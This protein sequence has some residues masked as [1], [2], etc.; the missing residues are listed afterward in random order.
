MPLDVSLFV[1]FCTVLLLRNE[2][3]GWLT[4]PLDVSLFVE[5]KFWMLCG[6]GFFQMY[7]KSMTGLTVFERMFVKG[8]CCIRME[9]LGYFILFGGCHIFYFF[10][11]Y[12]R[13]DKNNRI[14]GFGCVV[15]S[16]NEGLSVRLYFRM[17]VTPFYFFMLQCTHPNSHA[18]T[19]MAHRCP[20]GLC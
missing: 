1:D 18:R 8:F 7:G 20:A 17:S 11:L 3:V 16:L 9:A 13:C 6:W 14:F 5:M 2:S 10:C 4:M 15:A 12:R 19:S